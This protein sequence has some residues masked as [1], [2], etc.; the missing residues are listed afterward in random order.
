MVYGSSELIKHLA[1]GCT[2]ETQH[3]TLWAQ[4]KERREA[5]Q[6]CPTLC[7]PVDYSLPGSSLHGILQARVLEWVAI[8]FS[9][10]SSRPRD[11]TRVSRIPG[12]RFNLWATREAQS[13]HRWVRNGNSNA[14]QK[15]LRRWTSR[16]AATPPLLGS[17]HTMMISHWTCLF[18]WDWALLTVTQKSVF[19]EDKYLQNVPWS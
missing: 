19:L 9:R 6:S 17:I 12:S 14:W 18:K 11:Q 5:A 7:D 10:G 4:R 2:T 15:T 3:E 16:T 8:A 1:C 13:G